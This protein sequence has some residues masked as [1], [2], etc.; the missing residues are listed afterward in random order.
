MQFENITNVTALTEEPIYI[1]NQNNKLT[2][3]VEFTGSNSNF[4]I[5]SNARVF[6]ELPS[7]NSLYAK[8]YTTSNTLELTEKGDYYG[9]FSVGG[10]ELKVGSDATIYQTEICDS[11]QIE[12]PVD[13]L[14]GQ[15]T[16]IFKDAAQSYNASSELFMQNNT[17][18][19]AS[20]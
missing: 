16:D 10:G 3:D 6:V 17:Q 5:I 4:N 11:P 13:E 1:F 20:F 14:I 19:F 2:F 7:G 18:N 9:A 15:C 12:L 8:I